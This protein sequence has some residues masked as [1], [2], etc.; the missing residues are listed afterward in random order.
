MTL[1]KSMMI[2]ESTDEMDL[3]TPFCIRIA[4]LPGTVKR[5]SFNLTTNLVEIAYKDRQT[6][7]L[8]MISSPPLSLRNA[9]LAK[10]GKGYLVEI[11]SDGDHLNTH[12]IVSV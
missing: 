5:V 7:L 12:Q 4:P 11:T 3:T 9:A 10:L 1:A 8:K 6:S 2:L